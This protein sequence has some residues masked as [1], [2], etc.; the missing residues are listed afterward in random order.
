MDALFK[1]MNQIVFTQYCMFILFVWETFNLNQIV[2]YY[3]DNAINLEMH[4]FIALVDIFYKV[5]GLLDFRGPDLTNLLNLRQ[6]H[7]YFRLDIVCNNLCT[8]VC[9]SGLSV[10][11]LHGRNITQAYYP[12][13]LEKSPNK[14]TRPNILI[15][16]FYGT[17]LKMSKNHLTF[18]K[19][20]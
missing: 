20:G 9:F 6:L 11:D 8:K 19:E 5:A 12:I 10:I 7:H 18:F 13:L 3:K 4:L 14:R 17:G 1:A 2:Q 16:F 15:F